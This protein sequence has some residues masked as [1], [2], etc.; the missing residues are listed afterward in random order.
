MA[1]FV[2]KF[3][4][5]RYVRTWIQGIV[6]NLGELQCKYLFVGQGT[7]KEKQYVCLVCHGA[8]KPVGYHHSRAVQYV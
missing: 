5:F 4:E 7:S 6:P 3:Q 8:D 2:F 1:V